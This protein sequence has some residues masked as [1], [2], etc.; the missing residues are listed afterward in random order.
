MREEAAEIIYAPDKPLL[1][2]LIISICSQVAFFEDFS[3]TIIRQ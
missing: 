1:H 3:K 2:K